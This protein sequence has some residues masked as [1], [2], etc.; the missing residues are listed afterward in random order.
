MAAE[1]T[2]GRIG[3][4]GS[5]AGGNL[6]IATALMA[7]DRHGPALHLLLLSYPVCDDDFDRP[8]YRDNAEGYMLTRRQMQWFWDQYVDAAQ[9]SHPYVAPLKAGDLSGLPPTF[10]ITAQYD[11]LRD[12]AEA[13]ASR[14]RAAGVQATHRRYDGVIHGF[15][16]AAPQLAASQAA[17]DESAAAMRSHLLSPH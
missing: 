9:R 10:V 15:L 16:S 13:F 12:E 1:A 6:A 11:P 14:L 8:S 2:T 5:S 17:L 7:R 3:L 4:A